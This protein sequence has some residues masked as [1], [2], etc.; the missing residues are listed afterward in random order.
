M[1]EVKVVSTNDPQRIRTE[2]S[3]QVSSKTQR[4]VVAGKKRKSSPS[5]LMTR[6][7]TSLPTVNLTPEETLKLQ[8]V[9]NIL[10]QA[11]QALTEVQPLL[12]D[13]QPDKL[14][15]QEKSDIVV[16]GNIM[17]ALTKA[18]SKSINLQSNLEFL[19]AQLMQQD[20]K[21]LDAVQKQLTKVCGDL[22][23]TK[24]VS[25]WKLALGIIGVVAAVVAIGVAIYFSGGTAAPVASELA[26]AAGSLTAGAGLSSGMESGAVAM[27]EMTG[28]TAAAGA[29]DGAVGSSVA[30]A[31]ELA[32]VEGGSAVAGGS[33][34]DVAAVGDS[35]AGTSEEAAYTGNELVSEEASQT[36]DEATK[37]ENVSKASKWTRATNWVADHGGSRVMNAKYSWALIAPALFFGVSSLISCKT[38]DNG[39]IAK[40][41]T[42]NS[43]LTLRSESTNNGIQMMANIVKNLSEFT[44]EMGNNIQQA[45][46]LYGAT[47]N[48]KPRG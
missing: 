5:Y 27:T 33:A 42:K 46:Q 26:D 22:K 36:A 24:K 13:A 9:R 40:D 45:I 19:H 41:Q 29:T 14:T 3:I 35:A 12:Q 20:Q 25:G 8:T 2:A 47:M 37:A 7:E 10:T 17:L 1:T 16:C 38:E 30:G 31:G 21:N 48:I 6:K 11:N 39:Q 28:G 34:M 43:T 4:E 23:N 44:Q 18:C 32:D 15:D